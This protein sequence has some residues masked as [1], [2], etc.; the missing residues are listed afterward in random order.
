MFTTLL[1]TLF[2]PVIGFKIVWFCPVELSNSGA[3][4]QYSIL[5]SFTASE[6]V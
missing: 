6:P 2:D 3:Y 4:T 5:I 1:V